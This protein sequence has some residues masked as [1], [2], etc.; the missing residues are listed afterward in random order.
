MLGTT[1]I[2]CS[3]IASTHVIQDDEI[4]ILK[5]GQAFTAQYNGV[6]YS[7]AAQRRLMHAKVIGAQ[8]K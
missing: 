1:L 4:V 6:F 5:K 2:G 3:S 8:L 7:D